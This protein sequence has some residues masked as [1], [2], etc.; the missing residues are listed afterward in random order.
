MTVGTP[1]LCR[2]FVIGRDVTFNLCQMIVSVGQGIVNVGWFQS[3]VLL[4]DLFHAH[5][6]PVANKHD[7][8]PDARCA[9]DRLP[10]ATRRVL[11]N[12]AVV[13]LGHRKF[14]RRERTFTGM[15]QFYHTIPAQAISARAG[16]GWSALPANS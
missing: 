7:H 1:D 8:Y 4:N 16:V 14:L 2:L 3:R 12:V 10:S 5:A 6:L 9:D 15:T 13:K 11:F